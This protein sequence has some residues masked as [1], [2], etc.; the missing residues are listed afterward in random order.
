MKDE[1][2][3]GGDLGF[4]SDGDET[5]ESRE[6]VIGAFFKA[7]FVGPKVQGFIVVGD[8]DGDEIEVGDHAGKSLN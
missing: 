4:R 8:D 1:D 3:F 5:R 7:E 6:V 2:H